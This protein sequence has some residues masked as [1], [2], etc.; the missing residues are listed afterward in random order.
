MADTLFHYVSLV[1]LS[2]PI[3]HSSVLLLTKLLSWE[4]ALQATRVARHMRTRIDYMDIHTILQWLGDKKSHIDFSG[5][6]EVPK[7]RLM[8]LLAKLYRAEKRSRPYLASTLSP[9]EMRDVLL[10]DDV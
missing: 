3:L 1:Y 4:E 10:E 5:L 9:D 7:A 8:G 6:P 2:V